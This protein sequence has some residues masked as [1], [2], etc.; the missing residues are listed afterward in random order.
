MQ[1]FTDYEI[2]IQD[3]MSSDRTIELV[4][5]FRRENPQA[6]VDLQ[7]ERD[8]GIYDAMNKGVRRASGEWLYFLGSDDELH[9]QDAL[10]KILGS[11]AAAHSDVLYGNVKMVGTTIWAADGAIYDGPFDLRKLLT[12]N[13]CH[14]AIFYKAAFFHKV[15]SYNEKYIVVADWDFNMRCWAKGQVSYVDAI[16]ATFHAGGISTNRPDPHFEANVTGNVCRYFN[17]SP[18][19]PL[20]NSS[21]FYGKRVDDARRRNRI[22][23]ARVLRALARRLGITH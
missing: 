7:Q 9:D 4:D 18:S 20:I 6:K 8:K 15:G 21:E 17:L 11:S 14:Q 22:T 13:I 12:T 23:P 3:G 5:D 10:G 16:V 1:T 2:L 19:D